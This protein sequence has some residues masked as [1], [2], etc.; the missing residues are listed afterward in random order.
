M[1]TAIEELQQRYDTQ[2]NGILTIIDDHVSQLEVEIGEIEDKHRDRS[3]EIED[4]LFVQR[5]LCGKKTYEA[6]FLKQ[7]KR[8]YEWHIEKFETCYTGK[9][10]AIAMINESLDA[11]LKGKLPLAICHSD[12]DSRGQA[13]PCQSGVTIYR[14]EAGKITSQVSSTHPHDDY[15]NIIPVI[16]SNKIVIN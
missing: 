13:V 9:K 10:E 8:D 6:E 14:I 2:I 16:S 1:E 3:G 12:S 5:N 7:V 4:V 11:I 15:R